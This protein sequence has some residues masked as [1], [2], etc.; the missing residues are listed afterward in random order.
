MSGYYPEG[1]T[2]NEYHLAGPQRE[3]EDTREVYCR[4]E[5]CDLFEIDTEVAG[6][7]ESYDTQGW[8]TWSCEKCNAITVDEFEVEIL[9]YDPSDPRI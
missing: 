6:E 4:N 5:D 1:V 2:G 8:F 9:T 7:S 3:W